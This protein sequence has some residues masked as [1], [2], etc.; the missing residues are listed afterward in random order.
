MNSGFHSD[1]GLSAGLE[2]MRCDTI[3]CGVNRARSP[4]SEH[5][6]KVTSSAM[7]ISFLTLCL[8][9]ERCGGWL[10]MR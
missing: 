2:L 1:G 6:V 4:A 3:E 5:R 7:A 9:V 8:S 10:P